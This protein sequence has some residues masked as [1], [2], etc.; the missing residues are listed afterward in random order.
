MSEMVE[1][2]WSK[3]EKH[4]P[5]DC[6]EWKGCIDER[7]YGRFNYK[8]K[9]GRAHR[10]SFEFEKGEIPE[11]MVI[12]HKCDNP[13]CVKP[14]HLEIGTQKENVR[15]K[16]DRGREFHQRGEHH[17][18]AKLNEA[19]VMEIRQLLSAGMSQRAI[20]RQFNISQ[21]GVRYAAKGWFHV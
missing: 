6:W 2:F 17:G 14:D 4:G 11:G 5:S 19:Q 16:Y 9:W 1:R 15:D 7:G 13:R 3:V 21:F 8:G 18:N 20:A 10:A 12:R